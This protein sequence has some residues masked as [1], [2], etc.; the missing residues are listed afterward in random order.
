MHSTD[1][2]I[3]VK[4][5]VDLVAVARQYP[6]DDSEFWD[7]VAEEFV[8]A[9]KERLVDCEGWDTFDVMEREARNT[10]AAD[11]GLQRLATMDTCWGVLRSVVYGLADRKVFPIRHPLDA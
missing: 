5:L 4:D 10:F 6:L 2:A 3:R 1:R 7:N 11:V 8:L 9:C